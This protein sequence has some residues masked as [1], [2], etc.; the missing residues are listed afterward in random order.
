V[1]ALSGLTRNPATARVVRPILGAAGG[2]AAGYLGGGGEKGAEGGALAG[3]L[4]S[5]GRAEAPTVEPTA[6]DR[7]AALDLVA[8]RAP[9]ASDGPAAPADP[10]ALGPMTAGARSTPP[11]TWRLRTPWTPRTPRRSPRR[12]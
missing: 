4:L 10:D 9:P 6:A 1:N 11:T 12:V 8:Q 5:R 7:A 2:A 3:L